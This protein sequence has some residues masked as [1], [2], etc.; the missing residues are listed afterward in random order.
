MNMAIPNDTHDAGEKK[1]Y[2][3]FPHKFSVSK[4]SLKGDNSF[5]YKMQRSWA[6]EVNLKQSPLNDE[7]VY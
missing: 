1:F 7:D 2:L 3:H 5:L 6:F 4:Q